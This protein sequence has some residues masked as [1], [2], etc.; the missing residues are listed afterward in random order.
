MEEIEEA[1]R[2]MQMSQPASQDA[3]D[4]SLPNGQ[5]DGLDDMFADYE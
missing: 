4:L 5:M 2:H 3:A 1:Q